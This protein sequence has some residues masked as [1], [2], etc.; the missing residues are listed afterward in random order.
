MSVLFETPTA[1]ILLSAEDE[2]DYESIPNGSVYVNLLAGALA[3]ITEH[4][5]MY[6]VDIVK[7]GACMSL[8]F[9]WFCLLSCL[10]RLLPCDRCSLF[11][12]LCSLISLSWLVFALISLC[13]LSKTSLTYH[14][15]LMSDMICPSHS[16]ICLVSFSLLHI[17][18]PLYSM[19]LLSIVVFLFHGTPFSASSCIFLLL[20]LI[21][22]IIIIVSISFSISL[23]VPLSSLIFKFLS[24]YIFPC[25]STRY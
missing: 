18:F 9:F 20:L 8:T 4:T 15:L 21:I 19:S 23:R 6:P 5:V 16:H 11:S 14:F 10:S 22:I 7:V 25:I 24:S 1:S 2:V 12:A 3:G 17:L 13:L